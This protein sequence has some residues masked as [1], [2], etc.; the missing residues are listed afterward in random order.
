MQWIWRTSERFDGDARIEIDDLAR[1]DVDITLSGIE[2]EIGGTR[3]SLQWE[4]IPVLQG[5]FQA[6]DPGGSV[7]GRFYGSGHVEVGGIFERDV[8]GGRFRRVAL[9]GCLMLGSSR[10][11]CGA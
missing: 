2:G 4:D 10:K 6:R 7:D 3:D 8:F 9:I 5:A 11:I 1:P